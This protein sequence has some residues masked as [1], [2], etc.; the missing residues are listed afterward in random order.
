MKRLSLNIAENL[1]KKFRTDH[2][3]SQSEA[4][5]LKSLL[6]KLS[7][8]SMFKPLSNTAYG[9]CLKSSSGAC[10]MLINSENTKGRQ[11]YTIAHELY[12]LFCEENPK[13]HICS[14]E[15]GGKNA[16][17]YNADAFASALLLP[18]EGLF[19][20]LSEEEIKEQKPTLATIIKMEQYF[21]VSRSALLFRLKNLNVL[22]QKSFDLLNAIPVIE[23]A[24]QYGYDISLY[25]KGNKNLVIG[26]FGEKARRLYE[27]DKIS[28]GHYFELLNL[29]SNE[30]N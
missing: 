24:K 8:F 13:P 15:S 25:C 3:L 2:G 29:I 30:E 11:H 21:S 6:R 16:S 28:E 9:I 4:I 23:S 10:F 22:S 12:H 14:N 1:A 27:K 26:D 7:I 18:T 20:F 17:E 5:N 19:Q